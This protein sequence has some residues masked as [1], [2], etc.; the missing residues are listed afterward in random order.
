MSVNN[1]AHI[2]QELKTHLASDSFSSD[3]AV[4]IAYASDNSRLFFQPSV[5]VWPNNENEVVKIVKLANKYQFPFV[6]RGRGTATTGSSLTEQSGMV[7]STERLNAIKH[8]DATTRITTVEPGV[9]NG[10]LAKELAKDNL[11]WAPDPSS[12]NYCSIGGNLATAAAG[13][14]GIKY[15][16]VR[17]NV[18][19]VRAVCRDGTIINTGAK[20]PKSSVGLDLTRLIIGSEGSLAIITEA[21]LKLLP[22]PK[23]Q[24]KFVL[25]FQSSSS[26]ISAVNKIMQSY[27]TPSTLEFIDEGCIELIKAEVKL[28]PNTISLLMLELDGNNQAGIVEEKQDLLNLIKENNGFIDYQDNKDNQEIWN[29]RKVLSQKLREAANKKIN[30]DIVVPVSKLDIFIKF[31]QAESKKQNLQNLNFGHAG[32]GN[33]HVNI[34]CENN[35][36]EISKAENLIADMMQKVVDLEGSIS[37]EHGIGIAKR[38]YQSLQ[39]D[40]ATS[41]KQQD[42]IDLFSK[43]PKT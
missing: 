34:L 10:D 11:F 5:V 42:I 26:A 37:G 6:V 31:I 15:G 19:A 39:I 12:F 16:G 8:I 28:L 36:E 1:L 4:C 2:L 29:V 21:T 40:P 9:L 33:L 41:K 24:E 30:E 38:K 32:V 22:I 27:L 7:I 14:R 13:P 43:S 3:E 18:L 20:V 35:E 23:Y 25:F 17:E